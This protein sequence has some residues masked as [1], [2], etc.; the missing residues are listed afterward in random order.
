MAH[1][2]NKMVFAGQVPW[3]G[4]GKQLPQ[5]ATYQEIVEAAGFYKV[6]ERR[7]RAAGVEGFIEGKKALVR[8]DNNQVLS[9]VADSYQ[10]VDFEEVA[11]TLVKAAGGVG[12]VFHTAGTLGPT[13]VRGWLLGELPNPIKVKGDSSEI[14]KYILGVAS[15]DGHHGVVIKNVATRVVCQN[16]LGSALGE[17]TK[18]SVSIWHTKSA[19][20]RLQQAADGFRSIVDG[21]DL[22]GNV[23]NAMADTRFS[24]KQMDATIDILMPVKDEAK[25]SKAQQEKRDTIRSLFESGTGIDAGIRGTAW[26]AFQ[27]W[28]EYADHHRTMRALPADTSST[29]QAKRLESVW[30]GAGADLKQMALVSIT[31]AAGIN[32]V[33]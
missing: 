25:M 29:L 5:N 12:A 3:H 27:A 15:H 20:D 32:V 33:G 26:A 6:S 28:T 7:L 23:A 19:Q 14:R 8:G 16:T 13:G 30:F 18:F 21:Y 22:F 17:N 11:E 24:D 31:R 1:N 10:V 9:V 4:L 2:I